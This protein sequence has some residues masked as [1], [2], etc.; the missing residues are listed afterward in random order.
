MLDLKLEKEI[1][2]ATDYIDTLKQFYD[3]ISNAM[4]H[5]V[6]TTESSEKLKEMRKELP[7]QADRFYSTLNLDPAEKKLDKLLAMAPDLGTIIKLP[8]FH[9]QNF[10]G[11][12]HNEYT[13]LHYYRGKLRYRR[14]I[15]KQLNL[16]NIR[17]KWVI[18]NPITVIIFVVIVAYFLLLLIF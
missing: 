1:A 6:S 11:L 17:I 13:N 18:L 5:E 7:L 8:E 10:L 12:W 4:I 15:L 2:L 3:I 16:F 14:E 9:N